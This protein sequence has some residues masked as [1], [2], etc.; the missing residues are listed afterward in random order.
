VA[1]ECDGIQFAMPP[2]E[3]LQFDRALT[4]GSAK[5]LVKVSLP[6]E[7][8][9]KLKT[10]RSNAKGPSAKKM[11]AAAA[12]DLQERIRQIEATPQNIPAILCN[13]CGSGAA[14]CLNAPFTSWPGLSDV[15]GA[16]LTSRGAKPPVTIVHG[17]KG[18]GKPGRW[19]PNFLFDGFR[20]GESRYYGFVKQKDATMDEGSEAHYGVAKGAAA[21]PQQEAA[22]YET[23]IDFGKEGHVYEPMTG[24]YLGVQR[25]VTDQFGPWAAKWY[26]VLPYKVEALKVSLRHK[27]REAGQDI[28]GDV[29]V[30]VSDP[31]KIQRHVVNIQVLDKDGKSIMYLLRNLDVVDGKA[32]FSIPTALNDDVQNW[33]LVLTDAATG[34]STKLKL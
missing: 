20:D 19:I 30:L 6:A 9:A 21:A 26:A 27:D 13:E 11:D 7:S 14:V 16:V 25:K 31:A 17:V 8:A 2:L 33:T 3:M 23:T 29:Q 18:G 22:R 12:K 15:L 24:K 5:A 1:G 4:V 10:L 32:A 28:Q 34:V